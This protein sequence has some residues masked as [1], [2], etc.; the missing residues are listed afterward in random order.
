MEDIKKILK[1]SIMTV[2]VILVYGIAV[3]SKEI[4]VG[5]FSGAVVSIIGFQMICIDVK[6]IVLTKQGSHKRAMLGY[7]QRYVIY[8]VYLGVIAKFFGLS[9]TICSGIGLLNVKGNIIFVALSDKILKIRDK[10][11][12]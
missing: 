4:Y 9:M 5:M 6:K 11:L 12:R 10:Y 8:A 7:L 3:Q 2:F 1:R